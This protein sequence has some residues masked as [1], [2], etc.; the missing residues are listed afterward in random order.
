[1]KAARLQ[2]LQQVWLQQGLRGYAHLG[3][4]ARVR[5]RGSHLNRHTP[6]ACVLHG[7]Y[8]IIKFWLKWL[9]VVGRYM[10]SIAHVMI[11]TGMW[12]N[13]SVGSMATGSFCS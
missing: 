4:Q 7:I 13:A 10:V 6:A 2:V 5:Q 1:M 8:Q 12:L 3:G 9:S 11:L